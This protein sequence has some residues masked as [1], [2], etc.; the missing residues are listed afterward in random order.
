MLR[1]PCFSNALLNPPLEGCYFLAVCLTNL[2]GSEARGMGSESKNLRRGY[3]TSDEMR[4]LLLLLGRHLSAH[5][6][7]SLRKCSLTKSLD[8]T[9]IN[10]FNNSVWFWWFPLPVYSHGDAGESK[11]RFRCICKLLRFATS[12]APS[13]WKYKSGL[14][15]PLIHALMLTS[16]SNAGLLTSDASY[17]SLA[18]AAA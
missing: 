1:Q 18:H 10:V 12:E 5:L 17:A 7:G 3:C 13:G 15:N 11:C 14:H 4:T 8:Y 2:A 16:C 6:T 9:V